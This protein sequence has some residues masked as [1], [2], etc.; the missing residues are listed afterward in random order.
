MDA[1]G[2]Y[3]QEVRKRETPEDVTYMRNLQQDPDEPVETETDSRTRIDLWLPKGK[4]LGEVRIGRLGLADVGSSP[5][6]D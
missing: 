4:V 6:R 5:G 3:H 1:S 2:D